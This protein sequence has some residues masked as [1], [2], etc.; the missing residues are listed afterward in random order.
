YS[1]T[2]KAGKHTLVLADSPS[3]HEP[4]PGYEELPF[5]SGERAVRIEQERVSEWGFS[6]EVQP[7]AYAIDDFDF[8]KPSVELLQQTRHKRDYAEAEHEIYDY[9]GEYE[10]KDVGEAYVRIRLEELQS[11]VQ[12]MH[13]A[14]NARGIAVG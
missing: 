12:V 9:P 7:G 2:H 3:A 10:T 5:V 13:G 8:K 1:F 11:Q 14:G 4:F 6:W